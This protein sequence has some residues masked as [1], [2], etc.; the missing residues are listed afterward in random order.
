V[1][2]KLLF[3]GKD[4]TSFQP[5]RSAF[6]REDVLIIS[7][8]SMALALFL[9]RKNQPDLIICEEQLIDGNGL[10]FFYETRNDSDLATIPFAFLLADEEKQSD[11]LKILES[12]HFHNKV[13]FLFQE[14]KFQ[15]QEDNLSWK[16]K[17]IALLN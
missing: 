17:V 12:Y 13:N 3:V 5:L 14:N 15:Q 10:S 7:A 2:L 16:N 8:N 4:M 9:A 1:T 6:D 11:I